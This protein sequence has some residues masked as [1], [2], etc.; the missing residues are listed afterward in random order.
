MDPAQRRRL[1]RGVDARR[2]VVLRLAAVEE[3]QRRGAEPDHGHAERL[4]HL[5]RARH[6]EDRLRAG[7]D[8]ADLVARQLAEVGGHVE[9]PLGVAV[10][11]ADAAGGGVVD[12]AQPRH[13]QRAGDGGGAERAVRER[14][15]EVA[16]RHLAR[17]LERD[18]LQVVGAQADADLAV[19]QRDRGRHGA[20]GAHRLLRGQRRLDAGRVREAVRHVGGLERDHRLPADERLAHLACHVHVGSG[21]AGHATIVAM[22]GARKPH[23][24]VRS[25]VAG[26]VLGG[27]VV[28]A[29]PHARKR[30]QQLSMPRADRVRGRPVRATRGPTARCP[31]CRR[32]QR[33][34]R[35]QPLRRRRRR[36]HLR[37][38]GARPRRCRRATIDSAQS[39]AR[40]ISVGR[41]LVLVERAQH[42]V[43][44]RARVAAARPA[45]AAAHAQEVGRAERVGHRA[46]AVVALQAAAGLGADAVELQLDVVV[47]DDHVGRLELVEARRGAHR[48]P[49]QVHERLGLEQRDARVAER[50]LGEAAVVLLRGS[51]HRPAPPAGRRP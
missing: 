25:F 5:E 2:H 8:Q 39:A 30:R 12:A 50:R 31:T 19:H 48:A 40:S 37:R 46:Q 36:P 9:R 28:L 15:G 26:S 38:S 10:H 1:H 43:G 24:K 14:G 41:I 42:V 49:G 4:E 44:H 23:H 35:L 34:R 33:L 18:P 11:A 45:D 16:R 22:A 13:R 29:A 21:V 6:V 47:H 20:G 27:L 3:R 32:R 7:A 51:S 17:V